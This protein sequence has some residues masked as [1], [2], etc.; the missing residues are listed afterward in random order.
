M[1]YSEILK[2]TTDVGSDVVPAPRQV[3]SGRAII[4][5]EYRIASRHVF[6]LCGG[7]R[8][9]FE[10]FDQSQILSVKDRSK[11]HAKEKLPE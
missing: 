3:K 2:G 1:Q 7:Q 11:C 5:G 10:K 9:L 8:V 4:G 6:H